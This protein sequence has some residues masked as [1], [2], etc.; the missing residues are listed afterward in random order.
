MTPEL[1]VSAGDTLQRRL[2]IGA[3][4]RPGGG[5]HFRVWAPSHSIVHVELQDARGGA[6]GSHAL[7]REPAGYHS[8]DVDTARVGDRYR[9]RLG[10]LESSF[11]DPASRFQPEGPHGPSE[12]VDGS[13][14]D[15][16]DHGWS[17]VPRERAVI[18]EMHIGT[19]TREGTWSAAER[20]LAALAQLGITVL[21]LMPVA[22]FPGRFGWGYDGVNL[23][24]PT[25]LY[26]TP[27]DMR[28]FV[29]RAHALGMAVILDVVFNHFGPDGNYLQQ[30]APAYRATGHD[31]EW[32]EGIN[33]DGESSGPVREL[34]LANA[35]YWI[36]EFHLDGLRL[37]AT[38]SIRDDSSVHI[39]REIGERARAAAPGRTILLIA[40]NEPQD[41]RNL[42]PSAAGGFELDAA[43]NDDFHHTARVAL[44]GCSEAYYTD[45]G[46]TP[47][48]LVSAARRS[49][50][51]QGQHYAWQRKQ[52]GTSTAG[53]APSRFVHYLQNHDQIAN[54]AD[55]RRLH[56]LTSPARLRALTALLLLGPQI[57]MLF[58]GQECSASTR[59][60]YF[61]DHHPELAA[62]VREGRRE[63]L[64]QFA[65]IS[66]PHVA[67]SLPHPDAPETF[68]RSK[69]DPAERAPHAEAVALHRDLLRLRRDDPAIRAAITD[70]VDG[71]VLG[72]S[73]FLLRYPA[74][75]PEEERLLVINLGPALELTRAPE[76][77]LAPPAGHEWRIVWSSESPRYGGR[78]TEAPDTGVERWRLPP[79]AALFLAPSNASAND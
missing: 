58:Q 49:Y 48:E 37:D 75:A 50:L 36:D 38:H 59:F 62:K 51:Y 29:D 18:Y 2:P 68:D 54:S 65:S 60:L 55:G 3:E 46:G 8:G 76:P 16:R 39:L 53:F 19:F 30:F 12:I 15:W 31:T 78:T 23:F 11:P 35:S 5:A 4:P 1:V 25:R 27:D 22:D 6:R 63:F 43:W 34:F 32:G 56:E 71:A 14:Y 73:A 61:A 66:A 28:R 42:M 70:G 44:T 17:G 69:L 77:L 9:F 47:Q 52:R 72:D 10:T 13:A 33:F 24:A 67:A 20:E 7:A 64:S 45:Y 57:P 21:E 26:G 74:A 79:E 40:E 41:V